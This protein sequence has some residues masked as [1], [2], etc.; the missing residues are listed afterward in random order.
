MVY[1]TRPGRESRLARK[2][3]T[4][5]ELEKNAVFT[6]EVEGYTSAGAGVCRLGGRAVFVPGAIR[7]ERWRVRIVKATAGT[8]WGR[9]EELL[10]P[11]PCRRDPGC[12]S[13]PRCGGCSLRHMDYAEELAMK[14]CRVNDALRR[15]GGLCFSIPD[16]LPAGEDGFRRRKAIFNVG[17][18]GGKPIAGF[19]RARSHDIVPQN[20][21]PAVMPEASAACRSVLRWMER[22]AIAAYDPVEGR[23][24]IRHVF[25][26]SSR[27]TGAM[28]VTLVSSLSPSPQQT[29]ALTA[30]L[31]KEC[32]SLTGLVLCRNNRPGNVVLAGDYSV[33]WG[34]PDLEEEL[35]KLNFRLSP[36]S[37]FQV[38]PPQAEKL[39]RQ[40]VEYAMEERPELAVDL[41]CGTGTI[42]LCLAAAGTRVI[43][44]ETVPEAV[45]NARR[46][47]Q[48]NGLEERAEFFCGDAGEAAREFR[49]RGLRPDVVVVDPPRK[50]LEPGVIAETAGMEPERVVYVSCDPG[51]L[52]RDLALFQD[53]GYRPQKGL[54]VDMFP[55]TSHVETVVP[56]SKGEISSKKV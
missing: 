22:E 17:Q 12:G 7:G 18:A 45:E 32:P 27:L 21:C 56:L 50:G 38:N 14:L 10:T 30:R 8:V 53:A 36:P 46:N 44:V 2:G 55:R 29:Q 3:R 40:V 34:D 25:V 4:G 43:G 5:M 54:A 13:Y 19:Y 37:F 11:S 48:R 42:G 23:E 39:Y 6:A 15:I 47:A 33:L 16:I 28:V 9:G 49:R 51:T 24:G 26:R 52:A 41:Y 1:F 20:D 35:C 31:R